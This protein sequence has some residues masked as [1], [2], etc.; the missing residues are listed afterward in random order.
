MDAGLPW[1]TRSS[2]WLHSV[3]VVLRSQQS[4]AG[5]LRRSELRGVIIRDISTELSMLISQKQNVS[6]DVS[7]LQRGREH[8]TLVQCL[9]IYHRL[10]VR[11]PPLVAFTHHHE[12]A[13]RL[14]FP[15]SCLFTVFFESVLA[16][17]GGLSN[18]ARSF[19]PTGFVR[20]RVSSAVFA[21]VAARTHMFANSHVAGE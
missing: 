7:P 4:Q 8:G 21:T 11:F 20:T 19:R 5:L 10:F 13:R 17:G 1:Q 2:S 3:R 12:R 16:E 18:A 14:L 6:G 15:S 9:C